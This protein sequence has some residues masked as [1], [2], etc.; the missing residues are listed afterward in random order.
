MSDKNTPIQFGKVTNPTSEDL[1]FKYDNANYILKSGETEDRWSVHMAIHAAKKLADKNILTT[2]P[3]EHRV[4]VGA[5]LENSDV[6]VIAKNLGINLG[7]I[8]QE[9][10]TKDKEKAKVLNLE[11]QMVEER[12][13]REELEKKLDA[14]LAAKKEEPK[15]V[16]E[17]KLEE[18]IAPPK[19]YQ[20]KSCEE[21]F[22]S[23]LA[24]ARHSKKHK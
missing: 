1:K 4:F 13:K 18:K 12:K 8:R 23:P 15:E 19:V 20:C 21:A 16:V 14:V 6:E 7:K 10:M 24:L 9:A 3:E 5:Y 2:N 11:A 17:A 22:T